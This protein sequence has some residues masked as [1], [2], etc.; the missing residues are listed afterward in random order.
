MFVRRSDK[1]YLHN[2]YHVVQSLLCAG[3]WAA[4][5]PQ[6]PVR[7]RNTL[8]SA[9]FSCPQSAG[10]GARG[11]RDE[12][13]TVPAHEEL[14]V[15]GKGQYTHKLRGSWVAGDQCTDTGREAD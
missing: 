5:R 3:N 11:G 6:A 15:C 12:S 1:I 4:E 7:L 10:P 2:Y 8:N 14:T 13:D 9:Y